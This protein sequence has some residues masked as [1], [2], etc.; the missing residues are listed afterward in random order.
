MSHLMFPIK[1]RQKSFSEDYT[2]PFFTLLPIILSIC[3]SFTFSPSGSATGEVAF[4]IVN[5]SEILC[6]KLRE[7]AIKGWAAEG[8]AEGPCL[9]VGQVTKEVCDP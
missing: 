3:K 6:V 8:A 4:L 9:G 5:K 2:H 1:T 7:K